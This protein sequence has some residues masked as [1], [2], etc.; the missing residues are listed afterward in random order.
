MDLGFSLAE[1]D[2]HGAERAGGGVGLGVWGMGLGMYGLDR[3]SGAAVLRSAGCC[4]RFRVHARR[5]PG[6]RGSIWVC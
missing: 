2:L 4:F 5:V 1:R 6:L 3:G